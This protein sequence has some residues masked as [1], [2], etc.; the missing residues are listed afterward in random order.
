ME[1][2]PVLLKSLELGA[3]GK[4]QKNVVPDLCVG[5]FLLKKGFKASRGQVI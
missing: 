2:D 1:D 3:C 4:E 5:R